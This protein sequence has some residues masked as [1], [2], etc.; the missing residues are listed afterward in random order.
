MAGEKTKRGTIR[1]E[2]DFENKV[3][4][5]FVSRKM[6]VGGAKNINGQNQLKV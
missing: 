4:V 1:A 6:D 3:E 5:Q 2:L